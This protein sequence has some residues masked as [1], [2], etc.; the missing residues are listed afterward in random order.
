MLRIVYAIAAVAAALAAAPASAQQKLA[1]GVGGQAIFG[2][3]PLT[4]ADR[5]GYFKAEGL[6]VTINDFQGGSKSLEALVGGS[7]DVVVGAYE[8]TVFLQPKGIDLTAVYLINDRFGLAL[9]LLKSVAAKYRSPKDL[10]G[11][12]IGVTAPGSATSN[13]V[14]I[15]LAKDGLKREDVAMIG[16]GGGAGAIAAVKTRQVDGLLLSDPIITK[17]V[18]DGDIDVVV[19]SRTLEGQ[20]YMYGG[21]CACAS[22]YTTAKFIAER[23]PVVQ[24][25]VNAMV[26][27]SKWLHK[28]STDEILAQV[29][30]Q[31]MAG[32]PAAYREGT[33]ASRDTFTADGKITRE[34]VENMIRV[35]SKSGRMPPGA[36]IDIAKTFD[37]SFAEAAN[38][39]Y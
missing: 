28:S 6:D 2:Y 14:E 7:V 38:R 11:L 24:A 21:P 22:S 37:P 4:L 10:K 15:I 26:R 9:G 20:Q 27:A 13:A 39:K 32:D 30:P 29:P 35:M 12:K 36:T 19:D 25:Y 34:K 1:I 33:I 31:F 16:I 5:L 18:R 23:R 3:L 17:L 8:S